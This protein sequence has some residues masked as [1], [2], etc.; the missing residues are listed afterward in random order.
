M[1]QKPR[2][3]SL[4]AVN[5][6]PSE[7]SSEASKADDF[8]KLKSN[9]AGLEEKMLQGVKVATTTRAKTMKIILDSYIEAG[10]SESQAME[11][12]KKAM[13]LEILT[14]MQKQS[15]QSLKSDKAHTWKRNK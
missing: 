11:L 3:P 8:E 5:E 6:T 13:E 4:R 12:L 9:L 10:F 7:S 15:R 1:N 2:K 14:G